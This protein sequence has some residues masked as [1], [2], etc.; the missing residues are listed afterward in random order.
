MVA[1]SVERQ[2][3]LSQG[4]TIKARLERHP[5]LRAPSVH[6]AA[7]DP[8]SRLYLR[9]DPVQ[10]RCLDNAVRV[11]AAAVVRGLQRQPTALAQNADGSQL[12]ELLCALDQG[13]VFAPAV[14]ADL[15]DYAH[16]LQSDQ[17]DVGHGRLL[18]K[19]A[20]AAAC[21][22]PPTLRI[23][24]RPQALQE[25]LTP[26][27]VWVRRPR[28]SSGLCL[29]SRR[30]L[31]CFSMR[32]VEARGLLLDSMPEQLAEFDA[33]VREILPIRRI[34]ATPFAFM[35]AARAGHWG[36]LLTEFDESADR[37]TVAIGMIQGVTCLL[38]LVA[39][40]G[41]WAAGPGDTAARGAGRATAPVKPLLA[42]LCFGVR[43]REFLTR[44][45]A[46]EVLDT[47]ESEEAERRLKRCHE[48]LQRD[49]ERLA[50]E[51]EYDPASFRIKE[52]VWPHLPGR[53]QSWRAQ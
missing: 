33:L 39:T 50:G 21:P 14:M 22:G 20:A 24:E 9:T 34:G 1:V 36:Q 32:Y 7:A 26:G 38:L 23:S 3:T 43:I 2:Q 42:R 11:N 45:L 48:Q 10:A 28:G 44:L 30:E 53:Q 18:A 8:L 40:G 16:C 17:A 15:Q 19:L 6:G 37:L 13:A 49:Q 31:D 5:V 47:D 52:L 27:S 4:V 51:H 29:I 35:A 41:A 12:Q 46:A 25:L